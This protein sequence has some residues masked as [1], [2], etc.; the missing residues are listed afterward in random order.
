VR[1]PLSA[2][3]ITEAEVEAVAAVLRTPT[4]SLGPRLPEFEE[5]FAARVGTRHAVAVSSGTAGLHLAV[6]ACGVTPGDE[7]V[8]T[9]FS[10]VASA[11]AIVYEGGVPV[12]VDVDPASLNIDPN[13][14]EAAITPR[15]RA[16]LPVHVFGRPAAMGPILDI[17]RRHALPVI[18]DA[19][20]ALG[21]EVGGRAAGALGRCGVFGFY[22]NKQITTG[23]GGMIV[24][25][26][27]GV[28]SLCRSLRNHGRD[29]G[30][31]PMVHARLGYN[32][33]LAELACALGTAQ[34]RRLDAILE[35]RASVARRYDE[36]LAGHPELLVPEREAPGVRVSWFVY[37]VRL[38]ARWT[39]EGRDRIVVEM[40]RRGI[41]CRPYFPALHL[42]PHL[43]AMLGHVPGDFPVA[44][45]AADRTLALPFHGRL[46][47]GEIDE[48]CEALLDQLDGAQ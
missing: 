40:E 22:P 30:A 4:L 25:D 29:D 24:T 34:L 39:R 14:V 6:R 15:T 45:G 9:P 12:F 38:G 41:G 1:I 32:Y 3:D 18:E 48:V 13:R 2:P 46:Q 42:Q 36:R 20:E 35:A 5:A 19:C 10:F 37:V 23:E 21:A 27:P 28:A 26:D 16:L 7:V 11:N 47:D 17:A 33:R 43:Q 44:E 8:T 31:P